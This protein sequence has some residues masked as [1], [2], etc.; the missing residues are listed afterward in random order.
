MSPTPA[1]VLKSVPSNVPTPSDEESMPSRL[2]WETT[3]LLFTVTND[4]YQAKSSDL[5]ALLDQYLVRG[6]LESITK[7]DD[8]S[9]VS[10]SFSGIRNGTV[11]DL[12]RAVGE[13]VS[14]KNIN[15]YFTKQA[16]L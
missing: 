4:V 5:G 2:N 14:P 16:T 15:I 1:S 9:V 7:S 13:L 8:D 3:P 10:Y 6:R 12:Q 11:G